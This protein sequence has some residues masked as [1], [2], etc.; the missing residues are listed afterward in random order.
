VVKVG[1]SVE[2]ATPKVAWS[3]STP[4]PSAAV[5]DSDQACRSQDFTPRR[6]LGNRQRRGRFIRPPSPVLSP[7]T[8]D[9]VVATTRLPFEALHIDLDRGDSCEDCNQAKP[10]RLSA[11]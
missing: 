7:L 4:T 3:S 11:D 2:A 9:V 8:L 5:D 6:Y 10:A 1:D